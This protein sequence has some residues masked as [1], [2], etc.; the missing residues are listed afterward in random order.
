[1]E[2]QLTPQYRRSGV[3]R[4]AGLRAGDRDRDAVAAAL[5]EHHLAGRLDGDEFQERLE[6]C[7]SAKTY[8]ELDA[9]VADLP[10]EEPP[11]A[12]SS[13]PWRWDRLVPVLAALVA[14]AAVVAVSH[15]RAAWLAV[16][17]FFFMRTMLWRR[18]SHWGGWPRGG[19]GR[20]PTRRSITTL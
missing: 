15:G 6:R 9:L 14:V 8:G 18:R 4:A 11:A 16:P 2:E 1:M 20:P 17:G 13:R 10:L 3:G 7:L 12:R 5:R 19:A